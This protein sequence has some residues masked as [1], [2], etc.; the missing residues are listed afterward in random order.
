MVLLLGVLRIYGWYVAT[1]VTLNLLLV[2][3]VWLRRRVAR[4]WKKRGRPGLGHSA[5]TTQ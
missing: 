2:A 1:M 4:L 5:H 3:V